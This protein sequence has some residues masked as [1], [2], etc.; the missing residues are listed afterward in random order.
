MSTNRSAIEIPQDL[1]D[2]TKTSLLEIISRW[3]PYRQKLDD[4]ERAGMA[5]MA[6][7]RLPMA[8]SAGRY[9]QTNPEVI[10]GF[11]D[12]GDFT[13][14]LRNTEKA[15][16]MLNMAQ[17]LA[18]IISDILLVS[19]AEAYEATLAIYANAKL[20]A[21]REANPQA[22]VI[23]EDLGQHFK[24]QGRRKAAPDATQAS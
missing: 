19:N 2:F 15:E 20:L 22:R 23:A 8:Q 21:E 13:I 11:V 16:P 10:P 4:G 14:D 6:A 9:L 7:G 1:I 24:K 3:Q 18:E 5:K 17:Q 12:A